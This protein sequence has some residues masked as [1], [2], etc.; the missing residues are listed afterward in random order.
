MLRQLLQ[1]TCDSLWFSVFHMH[2]MVLAYVDIMIATLMATLRADYA[3]S[4]AAGVRWLSVYFLFI[5][6]HVLGLPYVDV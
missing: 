6:T 3:A 4:T 1:V 5:Y 2:V